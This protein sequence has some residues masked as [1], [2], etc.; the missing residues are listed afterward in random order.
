MIKELLGNIYY[1]FVKEQI[2]EDIESYTDSIKF[3]NNYYL[4]RRLNDLQNDILSY[5]SI[6]EMTIEEVFIK[7][8]HKKFSDLSNL[9]KQAFKE[10][11][12]LII[13]ESNLAFV[14]LSDY[15]YN[16][17]Y[18][19]DSLEKIFSLRELR[20]KEMEEMKNTYGL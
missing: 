18:I 3:A 1:S 17:D 11:Y 2:K 14:S 8:K 16:S 12:K 9:E 19:V 4:E 7:F 13:Q 6:K 20:D 15:V 5:F 10:K